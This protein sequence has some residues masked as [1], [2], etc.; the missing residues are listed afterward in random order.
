MTIVEFLLARIADDEAMAMA[1]RE[2][3]EREFGSTTVELHSPIDQEGLGDMG[4]PALVIDESRVQAECEAKR[5][6]VELHAPDDGGSLPISP[7]WWSC[8]TCEQDPRAEAW[9]E[10]PCST[11][12]ALASVYADHPDYDPAWNER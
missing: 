12:R 4:W 5:Q 8:S 1:Q 10:W 11:L 2:D 6:I 3:V 9:S 7:E